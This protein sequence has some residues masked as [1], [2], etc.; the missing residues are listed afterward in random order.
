MSV[1]GDYTG[2]MYVIS[3]L[4]PS[5][6]YSIQ[7][8]AETSAGHEIYST[9]Q[10]HLTA[11]MMDKYL[12]YHYSFFTVEAPDL[13]AIKEVNSVFL[14]WNSAGSEDVIYKVMWLS[15]QCPDDVDDGSAT[16]TDG[17]T[18]Y[19]IDNLRGG[20]LYTINVTAY[21]TVS[22]EHRSIGKI[23]GEIGT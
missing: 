14:T 20:T 4:M 17:S 21:N 6:A 10:D 11:G 9:A 5:T 16:I 8:A 23:T 15:D 7:V 2:G 1:S 18:S 22:S 12:L 13:S 19:T 3:G